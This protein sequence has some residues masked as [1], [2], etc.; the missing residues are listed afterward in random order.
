MASSSWVVAVVAETKTEN[1][2]LSELVL[3]A[4]D[5]N[6]DELKAARPDVAFVATV[7]EGWVAEMMRTALASLDAFL[8]YR[9]QLDAIRTEMGLD[10]LMKF[11]EDP[12]TG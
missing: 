5:I 6:V 4:L 9:A 11:G 2:K 1:E 10:M 3:L 12:W 7:M 8:E